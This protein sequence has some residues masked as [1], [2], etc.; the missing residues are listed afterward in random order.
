MMPKHR[1]ED[2]SEEPSNSG[3]D[4]VDLSPNPLI[5]AMSKVDDQPAKAVEL[6]GY[7][8]PSDDD[9]FV[10]LYGSLDLGNYIEIPRTGIVFAQ[11][12]DAS[13]PSEPSTVLVISTTKLQVVQ[14]LEA[15]FLEGDITKTHSCSEPDPCAQPV[16]TTHGLKDHQPSTRVPC[17][18]D[19]RRNPLVIPPISGQPS[20]AVP[21]HH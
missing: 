21:C 5:T 4:P 9:A 19:R 14:T 3:N 8:G 13:D 11:P 1:A 10:R 16:P 18:D 7:L 15:S 20:T 17:G 2:H 6:V 12:L